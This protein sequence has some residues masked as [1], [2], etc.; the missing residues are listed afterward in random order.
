M[1]QKEKRRGR[2]VGFGPRT[3]D[4][5]QR[6]ENIWEKRKIHA[7]GRYKCT[8]IGQQICDFENVLDFFHALNKEVSAT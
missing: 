6:H 8:H 3:Y 5:T 7:L 4:L 1:I 2:G